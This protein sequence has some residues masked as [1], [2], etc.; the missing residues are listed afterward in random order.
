M[1]GSSLQG[2]ANPEFMILPYVRQETGLLSIRRVR[3][4][5]IGKWVFASPTAHSYEGSSP[6]VSLNSVRLNDLTRVQKTLHLFEPLI[7]LSF[8]FVI[9]VPEG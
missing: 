5:G 7:A 4:R 8:G 6:E 9:D 1:A 2:Y 3:L